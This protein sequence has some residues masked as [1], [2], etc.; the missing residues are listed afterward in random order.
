[1][2]T[3]NLP[4]SLLYSSPLICGDTFQGPQRISE[5]GDSTELYKYYLFSYTYMSMIKFNLQIRHS[6]RLTTITIN[7]IE[8]F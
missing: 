8:H 6:E 3:G 7:K 5:T 2:G 4:S 1:M